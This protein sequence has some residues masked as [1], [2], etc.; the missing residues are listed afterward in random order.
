MEWINVKDRLPEKG[1]NWETTFCLIYAKG[2][3]ILVRPFDSYHNCWND[4][5]DDDYECDAVG[6]LITHWMPLPE[7]P[8]I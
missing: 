6:G 1:K 5:D 2:G 3:G 4:E 8:K 7:P